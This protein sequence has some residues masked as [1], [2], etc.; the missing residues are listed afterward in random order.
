[1]TQAQAEAWVRHDLARLARGADEAAAETQKAKQ[2]LGGE[3]KGDFDKNLGLAKRV[4]ESFFGS[5]FVKKTDLGNSPDLIRGL[6]KIAK[7]MGE[8]RFKTGGA[9]N[10]GSRPV[11]EDGRPRLKF[12]SMGD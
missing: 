4:A 6:Y 12:P 9:P 5:E 2:T 3:W 11:G 1:M 10:Q 7:Q 8:D